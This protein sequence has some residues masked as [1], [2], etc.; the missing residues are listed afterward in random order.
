MFVSASGIVCSLPKEQLV[1][2]LGTQLDHFF[3]DGNN[4]DLSRVVALALEK[5]AFCLSRVK[6]PRYRIGSDVSFNHLHS[7]QFATF[8]YFASNMAWSYA[9]DLA[10]A[11]KLFYLNKILNGMICM[12][13]TCLP[14]IFLIAHSVGIVLGKATYSDYLVVHQNTTVGTDK[15]I[16]PVLSERIVLYPGS[17]VIGCCTIGAG[18]V[19]S[20]HGL[21]LNQ[22][23]PD[24][25]VCFGRSPDLII[26]RSSHPHI[27]AYFDIR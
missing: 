7:E 5:L 2:Y 20:A 12:Y 24:A 21:V 1:R 4:H 27:E 10:L 11:E 26:K 16:A 9:N 8:L 14:D 6:L 22:R 15:G 13:D 17:A 19:V 23:V 25:S 18:S 3:P